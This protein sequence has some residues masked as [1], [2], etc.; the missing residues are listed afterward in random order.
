MIKNVPIDMII[1]VFWKI[2]D[3]S[4]TFAYMNIKYTVTLASEININY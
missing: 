4:E 2:D 1:N 3:N